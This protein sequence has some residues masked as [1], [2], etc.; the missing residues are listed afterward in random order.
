MNQLSRKWKASL[1]F[2]AIF[3]IVLS[4][5]FFHLLEKE[6][7]SNV[8][9][10]SRSMDLQLKAD[11][12]TPFIQETKNGHA[13]YS[14]RNGY[15]QNLVVHPDLSVSNQI[16]IEVPITTQD[17][18]WTNG[19]DILYVTNQTLFHQDEKGNINKLLE[20]VLFFRANESLIV[21]A[22]DHA[23][24][25]FSTTSF[26]PIKVAELTSPPEDLVISQGS[27]SF[28]ATLPV[29]NGKLQFTFFQMT[30]HNW[31][32]Y[33]LYQYDTNLDTYSGLDYLEDDGTVHL[34]YTTSSRKGGGNLIIKNFYSSIVF[35]SANPSDVKFSE[36]KIINSTTNSRFGNIKGF[37]IA[38]VD[39]KVML[40]F[41]A[42]GV[43]NGEN[44]VNIFM[45]EN[46]NEN[47]IATRISTTY[48]SSS[49]P[50]YV[51][52]QLITWLDFHASEKN[53]HIM[54]ASTNHH[55]VSSSQ[56]LTKQDHLLA[57]SGTLLSLS[58]ALI[59]LLVSFLSVLPSAAVIIG[60][61]VF[62]IYNKARA[63]WIGIG[64]YF[65]TQ[66]IFIQRFFDSST[67]QDGPFFINFAHSQFVLPIVSGIITLILYYLVR[68]PDW[69]EEV[70]ITYV[71]SLH[72]FMMVIMVGPYVF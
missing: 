6:Q 58:G 67:I 12:R 63:K 66:L 4:T 34:I 32:S 27:D 64:I 11:H 16:K 43:L 59:F 70:E 25:T 36:L 46:N 35:E 48:Q 19:I 72:L 62:N 41:G 57:L 10:W 68:N 69:S 65:V 52:D 54:G 55:A 50:T 45:A 53:Y 47:W 61:N 26:E 21:A 42:E 20:S 7:H 2:I 14:A 49:E 33:P 5:Q 13:F 39:G 40:L 28:V 51:N 23:I 18:F 44:A 37:H 1:P 22:Q 29:D 3:I 30:N 8:M 24:Y 56:D 38:K 31:S 71:V 60:M 9:P 15:L 17:Y